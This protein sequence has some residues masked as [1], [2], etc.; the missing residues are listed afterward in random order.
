[1]IPILVES[2]DPFPRHLCLALPASATAT[3]VLQGFSKALCG[4]APPCFFLTHRGRKLVGSTRL[5]GLTTSNDDFPVVLQL[6]ALLPGGK[7]GFGSMLR[8]QGGKMSAGARNSNNDSCRDLNGRRL[9]VLKEAKKL[10][11]YLEGES[12]RK[13]QM[14]EA[15]K[16]KYAKLEKMLGRTPR[17]ER[18]LA[19][20]AER[21]ADA[22]EDFDADQASDIP[23]AEAGPSRRVGS[24][25]QANQTSQRRNMVSVEKPS[26]TSGK[27]KERIEDSQYI[28]QSREIVENVRSAVA[29]AMMKKKKKKLNKTKTQTT[30]SASGSGSSVTAS[31]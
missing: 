8:S 15:Q 6:R 2:F 10:A 24:P 12:E 13:R 21:M 9:G 20:A 30:S 18:D 25:G 27:R 14:D 31:T 19:E 7:G 1:M 29:S 22:G 17:S 28:E 11:E 4:R 23:E 3:D 26:V 5:R 16:K